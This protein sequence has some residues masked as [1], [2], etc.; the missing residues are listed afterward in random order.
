ME[1]LL[2]MRLRWPVLLIT[3]RSEVY[4]GQVPHPWL[5]GHIILLLV[6]GTLMFVLAVRLDTEGKDLDWTG[7]I[8]WSVTQPSSMRK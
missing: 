6:R 1:F 7:Y 5:D 8:R 2:G 3:S 4:G